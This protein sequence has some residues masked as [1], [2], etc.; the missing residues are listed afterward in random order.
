MIHKPRL[1][2]YA[3]SEE[4]MLELVFAPAAEWIGRSDQDIVDETMRELEN[5]F[6]TEIAADGSKAQIRK[7]KVVKT[8]QSVYKAVAGCEALR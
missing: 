4:S 1:Q 5:L 7:S 3:N 6:P 8:A 2:E